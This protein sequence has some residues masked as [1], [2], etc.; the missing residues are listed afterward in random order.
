MILLL[1]AA[2]ASAP[3][4]AEAQFAECVALVEAD[5]AKAIDFAGAWQIDQGG[6]PA[7]QCLGLAYAAQGRW[8]P[9]M[10][11]FEQAAQLAEKERDGRA[12]NLWVQAGNAALAAQEAAKA[13]TAFD[14]AIASG[15]LKDAELGEVHLDRGRARVALRDTAGAREDID[16]ALKLV[17]ADPL[18]WLLSASLAR[19]EGNLDRAASDI[20]EAAKRSPDD[21]SVALEAG[22]IALLS[23]ANDAART[24]WEAAVKA[25]PE[26]AAGKAAAEA[27]KQFASAAPK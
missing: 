25:A 24:A 16:A 20:A 7:R 17:P 23:G 6:V 4:P 13:K 21:P 15:A 5:P 9:A 27:L 26:S 22:N 3:S 19:R 18:G 1:A 11:A 14:A 12:A 8:L 2:V 10:T